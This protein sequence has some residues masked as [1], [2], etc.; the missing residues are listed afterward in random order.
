[1]E[2]EKVGVDAHTEPKKIPKVP[3]YQWDWPEL[4]DH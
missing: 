3:G 2:E 1:M 4:P